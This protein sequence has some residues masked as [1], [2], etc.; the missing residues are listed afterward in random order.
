MRGS[1][2]SARV[3]RA[4]KI[5]D[6]ELADVVDRMYLDQPEGMHYLQH[7]AQ[8]RTALHFG[9]LLAKLQP[10]K[11]HSRHGVYAYHAHGSKQW[12]V[13]QCEKLKDMSQWSRANQATRRG[14]VTGRLKCLETLTDETQ[15]SVYVSFEIANDR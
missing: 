5:K 4:M 7:K 8:F 2:L 14:L 12:D 11:S 13:A 1:P 15:V 9:E 6:S 3:M 10:K